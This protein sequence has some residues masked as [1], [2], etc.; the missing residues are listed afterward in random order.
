MS[1]DYLIAPGIRNGGFEYVNGVLSNTT[2]VTDFTQ[3]DHWIKLAGATVSTRYSTSSPEG[4]RYLDTQRYMKICNLTDHVIQEGD[5]FD[6][7]WVLADRPAGVIVGLCYSNAVDGVTNIAASEVA[8][9]DVSWAI[10]EWSGSYTF[11]N[12]SPAIGSTL[13]LMIQEYGNNPT[14]DTSIRKRMSTRCGFCMHRGP[15]PLR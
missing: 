7:Q 10:G 1:G 3:I 12:G 8:I 2:T 5:R 14:N 4:T 15:P 11:T 6:F 13:G 9:P